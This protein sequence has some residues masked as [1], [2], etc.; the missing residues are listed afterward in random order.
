M[1]LRSGFS[2][3]AVKA[4]SMEI[5]YRLAQIYPELTGEPEATINLLKDEKSAGILAKGRIILQRFRG[6][7]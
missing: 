3:V 1:M 2:S 6:S 4:Y 5:I 7:T